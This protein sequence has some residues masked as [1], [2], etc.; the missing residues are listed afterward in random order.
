MGIAVGGGVGLLAIIAIGW[1]V[2]M[3]RKPVALKKDMV[4]MEQEEPMKVEKS[5]VEPVAVEPFNPYPGP[6]DIQS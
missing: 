6:N 1:L 2:F 5:M 3:R 4:V